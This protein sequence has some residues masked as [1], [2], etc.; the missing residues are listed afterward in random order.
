MAGFE[1]DQGEQRN[2]KKTCVKT[3]TERK[4]QHLTLTEREFRAE[5]SISVLWE[6][7]GRLHY[8]E[9]VSAVAELRPGLAGR[10]G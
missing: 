6:Q 10:R 7:R 8:S 9:A 5:K 3:I 1:T 4:L 2:V